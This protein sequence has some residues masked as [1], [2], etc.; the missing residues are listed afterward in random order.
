MPPKG[1]KMSPEEKEKAF[2]VF[3]GSDEY[4]Q[5]FAI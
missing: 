2:E 4:K 5:Y 3:K 1:G